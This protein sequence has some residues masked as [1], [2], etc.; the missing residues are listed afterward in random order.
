MWCFFLLSETTI[1]NHAPWF[2]TISLRTEKGVPSNFLKLMLLSRAFTIFA[3]AYFSRSIFS[4][5][6]GVV[7]CKNL[8]VQLRSTLGQK[9]W[10]S[11]C[12]QEILILTNR[13]VESFFWLNCSVYINAENRKRASQTTETNFVRRKTWKVY[14]GGEIMLFIVRQKSTAD[15]TVGNI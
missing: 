14:S 13:P 11:I 15:F 9:I 12:I 7:V 1:M 6:C 8:S 2:Q 10:L 3:C 4:L 5:R